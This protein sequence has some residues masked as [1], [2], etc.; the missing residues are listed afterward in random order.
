MAYP[1]WDD[2]KVKSN[3]DHKGKMKEQNQPGKSHNEHGYI[4]GYVKGYVSCYE[5]GYK[6]GKSEC[7]DDLLESH[8]GYELSHG[9]NSDDG[10]EY[11]Y[12]SDY[13]E[14]DYE[15]DSESDYNESSDYSEVAMKMTLNLIM[16]AL[17]AVVVAV[18]VMM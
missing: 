17:T 13:S 6:H 10:Y 7:G 2:N 3:E 4:S 14:D 15:Y 1:W 9:H 11:D 8:I 12:Y 5:H 18:N 16:V